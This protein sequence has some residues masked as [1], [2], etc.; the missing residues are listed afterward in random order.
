M[1]D[2]FDRNFQFNIAHVSLASRADVVLVAPASANIIAKMAYG[3]ADDMLSTTALAMTC[4][5]IVSPA[6]NVNMFHNPVVQDNLVRLAGYGKIIIP[7]ENGYL[8]CGT[9]GDGKMPSED[10]LFDYIVREIAH[11]KDLAGRKILVT[12]GPT[13]EPLDPVRFLT[14]HST[15]K[16]GYAIARQAMLR[17]A[18][19]TLVSGPVAL[20]PPPFIKVVPVVRAADMF[21][22][23]KE[24]WESQDIIIKA[25]AVA[26]YTPVQT[27]EDKIKKKDGDMMLALERTQDILAWLGQHK[28][29]NQVLCGFSMETRDVLENS[30]AK[31]E[32]KNADMI[33][34]NCLK[35]SGAGFGTDTNHLSLI[36]RNG[37]EDLPMLSKEAAA[38]KLLDAL[39]IL[40][41]A[42]NT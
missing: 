42:R 9:T 31:L 8:A 5:V 11:E 21:E 23:V 16:M 25:A 36:S 14:N 35:E 33:A 27:A 38:D 41:E 13:R 28:K 22:A 26:D 32:K 20:T 40:L 2:T 29:E 12:A 1:V 4:P 18:E 3:I 15:G 34:A 7:P 17:G 24:R 6:M 19:V 30:A 37:V 39:K 10:V